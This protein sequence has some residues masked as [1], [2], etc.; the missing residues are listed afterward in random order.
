MNTL[1]IRARLLLADEFVEA[2]RTQRGIG[3]VVARLGGDKARRT[4][5]FASSFKPCRINCRGVGALTGIARRGRNGGGG[6]RMAIAEIDQRRDSVGHRARRALLVERAGE[7]HDR[8][9]DIRKGRRLVLQFGDDP[10][11]DL[12]PDARSARDH[13]LVAHRDRRRELGCLQR[14][15]HGHGD[16]GA[17]ALHGLQQA[18]PFALDVARKSE[19]PDLVLAH[20]RLDRQRGGLAGRRQRLQ[21]AR[22]AMH[23]ISDAADVEDDVVLAVRIDDALELAD[24]DA[25]TF[26]T[27]LVR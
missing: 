13:R 24:H 26:S 11:G 8:R 23:L 12:L 7:M 15:E 5:H 18:E 27:A 1:E 14:A 10:L 9:V 22:R 2:L 6:L 16:L 19:Q 20:M 25:A 17:D 3:V 21:R 4:A